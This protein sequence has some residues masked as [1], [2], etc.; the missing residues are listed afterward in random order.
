MASLRPRYSIG[1]DFLSSMLGQNVILHAGDCYT[2]LVISQQWQPN[3][4]RL[5]C[6]FYYCFDELRKTIKT[7]DN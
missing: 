7:F 4:S 2:C 3:R 6:Y 5:T 1:V